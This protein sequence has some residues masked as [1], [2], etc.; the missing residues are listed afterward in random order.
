[1][2]LDWLYRF[3]HHLEKPENY[4]E[5]TLAAYR[6]GMRAK[7]SI[8]GVAVEPAPDCC[9]A[10]RALPAAK[11]YHPDDA[12]QLPLPSCPQG[13]HCGCV[14]RPVMTYQQV[15]EERKPTGLPLADQAIAEFERP[16]RT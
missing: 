16:P 7:G 14:Y 1:M 3:Q 4:A 10:A 12:P 9:E 13:R 11:V 8:V 6:L 15:D 2:S 5:K